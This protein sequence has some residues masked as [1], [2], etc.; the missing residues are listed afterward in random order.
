MNTFRKARASLRAQALR[1]LALTASSNSDVDSITKLVSTLPVAYAAQSSKLY[2]I[3]LTLNELEIILG[4]CHIRTTE[5]SQVVGVLEK[6]IAPYCMEVSRQKYTEYVISKYRESGLKYPGEVLTFEMVRFLIRVHT[7]IPKLQERVEFLLNRYLNQVSDETSLTSILSLVG[8]L[9]AFNHEQNLRLLKSTLTQLHT[10]VTPE[11]LCALERAVH[12]SAASDVL[13]EY[14]DSGREV[15]AILIL[16]LIQQ[17]QVSYVLN[18]IDVPKDKSLFDLLLRAKATSVKEQESSHSDEVEDKLVEQLTFVH[19]MCDYSFQQ[20]N[21]LEDG[22]NY[23]QFSSQNRVNLAFDAKSSMLE[24]LSLTPFIGYRTDEFVDIVKD[25]VADTIEEGFVSNK[26]LVS[27]IIASA[28]ILNYFSDEVSAELLRLFPILVSSELASK[29]LVKSTSAQFG[30]GLLPLKE[31]AVVS[32]IYSINNLL[33]FAQDGSPIPV[34]KEHRAHTLNGADGQLDKL[35]STRTHRTNTIGTLQSL[36]K[37]KKFEAD[38]TSSSVANQDAVTNQTSETS[39]EYYHKMLFENVVIATTTIASNYDDQSI[40]ALSI[41]ILKQKY[42]SVSEKLDHIIMKGLAHMSLFVGQ[43][44]FSLLMKFFKTVMNS[45]LEKKDSLL[46]ESVTRALCLISKKL[47]KTQAESTLY[48]I[49][50]QD[51]LESVISRGDVDRLEHH[52]SH[53][54]I[55]KVADQI[56]AYIKPLSMVLP[57]PDSPPLDLALDET[58]TNMMRNFWFNIVIHGFH[59]KSPLATN[60][61]EH[62]KR[63]AY[64]SPP[65]ASD[66]PFINRE[67]SLEMNT[68]L[69]RGSSN[70]NLRDQK[71]ILSSQLSLSAVSAR[72]LST[73]KVMFLAAT[74]FMESLRCEAGDCS[75]I[76]LYLS[77]PTISDSGIE[78]FIGTISVSMIHKY[79]KLIIQGD[80]KIFSAEM[81]AQ[82]LT[83]ILLLLIHREL[84]LQDA[85]FQCCDAFIAEIPSSLCHH[86]SLYTLLDLLSMLFES[87]VQLET[88]KFEPQ[89][90]FVLKHSKR[91]VLLPDSYQWRCATLERLQKFSKKWVR[92]ILN[93][94]NQDCKILLQSYISELSAFQRLD[95]VEFGVSF[96]LELAG[97]ILPVDRELSTM[98][99]HG[100]G[101]PNTISGF[102]SQHAWRS[103]FLIERNFITSPESVQKDCL[104]LKGEIEDNLA[105]RQD[106]SDKIVAHYLDLVATLL[107]SGKGESASLVYDIVNV[108]FSIFT[109][110][111]MKV[112]INVWLSVIKERNDV[113]YLLLSEIGRSWMG[114]IDKG[115]GLFSRDHDLIK[116]EFSYMEYAPYDKKQIN[117]AAH[118]ASKAIQPHTQI[119]KF[120]TSHFEATMFVSLH[121]L[122]IFTKL[123]L[124]GLKSL[125]RASLHPFARTGRTELL[126][127]ALLIFSANLKY[128]TSYATPVAHALVEGALK[129]FERPL[130]WPFGS[131]ELK[132]RADLSLLI[133]LYKGLSRKQHLR[134][135]CRYELP[136]LEY[137]LLSEITHIETWLNPLARPLEKHKISIEL[138]VTAFKKCPSLAVNLIDRYPSKLSEEKL[139]SLV[140]NDPIR[141]VTSEALLMHLL[142]TDGDLHFVLYWR[143]V[144]P[145]K[146]I[147][148]F[149]PK[150]ANNPFIAQF[151][152]SALES[153]DV[154]LTFFYVPQIVQCLRFDPLGYVERFIIDTAKISVL[155]SHQIIWNMLA[156]SFKDD[157]G[158]IPDDLKPTLDRIRDKMISTFTSQQKDFF[159]REFDFFNEVTGISG[160]LKP[161]IKK[162]KAEKK[163][164]I[165]EEMQKIAIRKD[166]YLPSYPEA[167][168]VDI[169]R[170][171]GKPLQSHAKA[172]FMATFKIKQTRKNVETHKKET[173]EKWQAA[174]FK[175]GDDCR[176]DVLALQ[177]ISVFRAVWSGIGL[178]IFV[179]PYRVTATAP[180]CGVIDVLPNSISRDMLGREAVN[181]LYEYFVTKFGHENTIEFQNARNNFVKSLAGYS[182]ISYLLQFKDR[183]NG[184]IMYDDQGNCLHVDF[185]F[186]FDIV[187]GGVKFEAV[188]FKLTKEMVRVMGGSPDTPAFRDFQE[189]CVKAYL[190]ARPHMDLIIECVKPMLSSGLPCFKGHKTIKNLEARFVPQKSDH[191][192]AEH[193][194]GLIK[195][196]YESIFTKGYDEFQRLTN[197]I[198][199]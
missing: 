49:Y 6:C 40:M 14:F 171:S 190:A 152:V 134:S 44:E 58:T 151:N 85:A 149:L 97:T 71:A 29:D 63:I 34:I 114:S 91:R 175:V 46:L 94:A 76:L 110:G 178:D 2:T 75:K 118:E 90:E 199:Y 195:R 112:A 80:P 7:S 15:C 128:H 121:L 48:K 17:L 59:Q 99:K 140:R 138:I 51:L 130:M 1:K 146:S 45:A 153:H 141:C 20:M 32:A 122:Q 165:D 196:S 5:V 197:G 113:S 123:C 131:N 87:V 104:A 81:V 116:E 67:T 60:H 137:L 145:L 184:N 136:L 39:T 156:N 169:D 98:P 31:D 119:I 43:S 4:L 66:F 12:S 187:P 186:I 52:R 133:D 129:W 65:L 189:I 38:K 10:R 155:F 120:F 181:G 92:S 18:L 174:I 101:Q 194:M 37:F 86:S 139:R 163:L 126:N 180:G 108:P 27:A 25:N 193:M 54:E 83:S 95:K 188:P 160:K 144:S 183:H 191:Q 56:A 57:T 170:H 11:F 117:R 13:I 93:I 23:V 172:P 161:F 47:L 143:P 22:A 167:V 173:I 89:F 166:V 77:D 16:K 62:L 109:S 24:I 127:F 162:S 157:E 107:I 106:V 147:N 64:N 88:R 179:F 148:L 154:N 69:R 73:P 41:T 61:Y 192:A 79:A 70:H 125:D 111:V 176:Q 102:L 68:I 198:P 100:Y 115:V 82:R 96:A 84:I 164:K 55:S 135:I 158:E 78:K 150:W 185:G 105:N 103:R 124:Y 28:S 142:E 26:L 35:F 50:L 159:N 19:K 21:A 53:V 36:V 74:I 9:E 33:A 132:I 168:V 3:P 182:V 72:T 30:L 8:F 177:L 42:R